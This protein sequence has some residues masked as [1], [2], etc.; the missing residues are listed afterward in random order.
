M[1]TKIGNIAGNAHLLSEI[2]EASATEKDYLKQILN[3]QLLINFDLFRER[4]E[5]D[6]YY[7]E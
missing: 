6:I 2:Y 5:S 4:T 3:F 7:T 1:Y